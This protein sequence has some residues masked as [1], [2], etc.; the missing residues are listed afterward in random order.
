M[1]PVGFQDGTEKSWLW[2]VAFH[3]DEAQIALANATAHNVDD[4]RPLQA[5]YDRLR[6]G[7]G[8]LLQVM[9]AKGLIPQA[10]NGAHHVP[11]LVMSEP[12]VPEQMI[13]DAEILDDPREPTEPPAVGHTTADESST[14][15]PAGGEDPATSATSPIVAAEVLSAEPS[16]SDGSSAGADAESNTAGATAVPAE[17][18]PPQDTPAATAGDRA[19]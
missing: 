18:V 9:A 15:V 12:A 13:T 5:L 14:A 8:V 17:Q 7:Q 19:E 4:P 1:P 6:E 3:L 11:P 10:P 16:H 2:K